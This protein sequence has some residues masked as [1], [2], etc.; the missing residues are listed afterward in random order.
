MK[1]ME[2]LINMAGT[3]DL[4][5]LLHLS[6]SALHILL[7]LV[8]AWILLRLS[9]KAIRMLQIYSTRHTDNNPEELKRIA[10]LSRVFRYISSV[11]I[12]VVA[13]MVVLSELGVSIAPI[14][15]TAGVLGLAVGFAAQSL[16]K[17]Y[18]N[19]IFLLLEN[20]VRQGDV[21]EAGGKGGLVEEVTLRYIKMR[22][23]D[24]NVHFIPNGIITTV[25]N[26]SRGFAYS[27]IDVGVAYRE[28]TDAVMNLMLQ[29]GENLRKDETIGPKIMEDMEMAGVDKWDH[30]AVIIR[31]RFKVLPLEQWGVRREF[32]R[33]LKQVFDQHGI[34]I[35]Y[36]HMTIYPGQAK[37]GSAPSLH[38]ASWNEPTKP[39]AG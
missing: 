18:F 37:D 33:R 6:Q 15:A 4:K 28:D 25:T 34:E 32:L 39:D 38:I 2:A 30:S 14:L 5:E 22:D 3:T 26:M 21:V 10:T 35:P 8:L 20:Q 11:V 23:Y 19:G 17:D 7:I 24:G 27:V 13:G 31:C 16:I 9:T 29:V 12:Y 36:P 1:T